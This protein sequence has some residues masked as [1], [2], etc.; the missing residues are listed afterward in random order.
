MSS[1]LKKATGNTGMD[2]SSERGRG[3]GER[4]TPFKAMFSAQ[5]IH[6][7]HY[8]GKDAG[9]CTGVIHAGYP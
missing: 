4:D 8:M 5:G 1:R 6:F 2:P 7:L 3:W 9:A